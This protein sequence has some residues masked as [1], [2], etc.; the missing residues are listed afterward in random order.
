MRSSLKEVHQPSHSG[1]VGSRPC[2]P[3]MENMFIV[4]IL[5]QADMPAITSELLAH[6][7]QSVSIGV[8]DPPYWNTIIA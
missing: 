2:N 5:Y 6:I 1:N 8:V 7:P 4:S 3:Q